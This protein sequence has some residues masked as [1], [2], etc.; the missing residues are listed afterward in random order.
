VPPGVHVVTELQPVM[1]SLNDRTSGGPVPP[2]GAP[3]LRITGWAVMSDVAVRA[4][5]VND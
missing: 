1:A 5:P 2:R 3:V 4:K